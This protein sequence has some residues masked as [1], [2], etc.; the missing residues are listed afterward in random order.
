MTT[1]KGKTSGSTTKPRAKT[2]PHPDDG[3][4]KG[5]VHWTDGDTAYISIVFT[6]QAQQAYSRAAWYR[7]QGY[8]VR[9]GGPGAFTM[10]KMLEEAAQVGGIID[11][12]VVRHNPNA[13][14]ASKGC[15]V[16]CSFCIVPAMEGREF[17]LFPNFTPRPVL[18]DNNLSALPPEYQDHIIDRY[19]EAGVPLLDA[20]SG[21]EPATFDEKVLK[22]WQKINQGP[23]RFAYDESGEEEDVRRVCSM[24]RDV[25]PTRKR[26]YVLI[27]NE[28]RMEC[29]RRIHQVIMWGCE[30]HVQ[31]V[32]R[33]NVTQKKPWIR[34]DWT[35]RELK[36]MARW[37]N[38]W[39]W[40]RMPFYKYNS[41]GK[42][43]AREGTNDNGNP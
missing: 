43:K 34:Y 26:V 42:Q 39:L 15:P 37:A 5:I 4:K 35:E 27:G 36:D 32:M 40:R 19:L 41:S 33:L 3:W 2:T 29:L 12:T 23:W 17:T 11:D 14:F 28:P 9:V 30:P 8:H 31:P 16:G 1:R 24:L 22:R 25:P 20:N 13:T 38:R 21:F 6:W 7:A 18:C 10:G